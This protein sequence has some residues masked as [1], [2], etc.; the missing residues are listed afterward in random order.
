MPGGES[1]GRRVPSLTRQHGRGIDVVADARPASL[2]LRL[3]T[4]AQVLRVFQCS[5]SSR[6]QVRLRPAR[7]AAS[8]VHAV[9][10][11]DYL[12]GLNP[13]FAKDT[14]EHSSGPAGPA[15][16]MHQHTVS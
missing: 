10:E 1:T 6:C 8:L 5:T 16:T 11:V 2:G 15:M 7:L 4:S 12:G 14:P 3:A 13:E 9:K